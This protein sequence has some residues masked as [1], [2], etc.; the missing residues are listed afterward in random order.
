MPEKIKPL[1]RA[2]ILKRIQEGPTPFAELAISGNSSS[3]ARLKARQRCDKLVADGLILLTNI[4]PKK[5]Y[6]VNTEEAKKQ[7]IRRQIEENSRHDTATGCTVWTS[8]SDERRGPMMRQTL[9]RSTQPVSVRRWL[10]SELIGR[11]LSGYKE[12]VKMKARCHADCIDEKHMVRKTKS[13]LL[14]GIPK[15]MASRVAMH[16]SMKK[17]WGKDPAAVDVIRS[18]DKT[19]TE[20]AKVLNMSRSN[21]WA[22]RSRKTHQLQQSPFA[23]LGAR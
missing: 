18:S 23:G 17:H 22:I 14:K 6:I 8:Y 9:I 5:F 15:S 1:T 12:S 7:A 16:V 10:F 3:D 21:V 4:G 11:E 20:L 2:Q 19:T 13:Q